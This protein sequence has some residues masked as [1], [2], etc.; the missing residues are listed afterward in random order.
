[1]LHIE[2]TYIREHLLDGNFG[3]E[4][5]SLRVNEDGTFAQTAHPFSEE[6]EYIVKDFCENQIEINTS[7]T[8][9]A[10]E[11]VQELYSHQKKIQQKLM[12]LPHREVLWC[13][14]N[15][16]YIKN[17]QDIPVAKFCGTYESKAAY[18]N[19]LSDKYGRYKMTFSGIHVNYSFRETLLQADFSLSEDTDFIIYKN[20]LYLDLAQKMAIYG[21][22]LVAITAASPILDSSFVEKGVFGKD[23]FAGMASVRCSEMGYWNDF[24]PLFDYSDIHSYVNSIREYVDIGL[25]LA[26]SELYYPIRLKPAGE[27]TLLSLEKKGVNHIELRMFDLNPLRP[28]GVEK[29]DIVF[30]QLLMVWLASVPARTFSKREQIQAVQNF[31]N[32]AHYDLKTVKITVPGGEI[33]SVVHAARN[34]I[35]EMKE[36]YGRLGIDVQEVLEFEESKFVDGDNRYAWQIRKEFRDEYVKKGLLLARERQEECYV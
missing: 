12:D 21:W 14:S 23:V 34:I 1:M 16:P 11:A 5:E 6:E 7:V 28:E 10:E 27:N 26:P 32:A 36:F 9:G 35:A 29:K 13:F 3:L 33:C 15:P 22:I 31:K 30:A 18:R 2:D 19:Y 24:S 25:L 8:P 4:K 17:E 20:K